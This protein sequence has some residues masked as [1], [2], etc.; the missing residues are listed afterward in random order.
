MLSYYTYFGLFAGL[1]MHGQSPETHP[2]DQIATYREMEAE[3]VVF[4]DRERRKK[5][6]HY[7]RDAN[8]WA[9]RAADLERDYFLSCR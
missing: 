1:P 2:L 4:A 6:E 7:L 3:A 5:R 8:R 9:E